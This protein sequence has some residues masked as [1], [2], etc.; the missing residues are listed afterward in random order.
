MS[1]ELSRRFDDYARSLKFEPKRGVFITGEVNIKTPNGEH[2]YSDE[3]LNYCRCCAEDFVEKVNKEL[4]NDDNLVFGASLD[5]EDSPAICYICHAIL[6]YDLSSHGVEYELD[7]FM[8]RR[9]RK[10]LTAEDAYSIA[11]MLEAAPENKDVL[12]VA[13]RAIRVLEL[14]VTEAMQS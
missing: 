6:D 10:R 1:Y 2:L 3:G 9:F 13:N 12:R 8:R 4:Q 11:R 5:G 7:H 14:S